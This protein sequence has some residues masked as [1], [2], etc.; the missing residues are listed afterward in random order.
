MFPLPLLGLFI[1]FLFYA[2]MIAIYRRIVA[3]AEKVDLKDYNDILVYH[4]NIWDQN[5]NFIEPH[6]MQE[7]KWD[8]MPSI[9]SSWLNKNINL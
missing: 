2:Y 5:P 4:Q 7:T 6:Y 9:G 1:T 8:D 3:P